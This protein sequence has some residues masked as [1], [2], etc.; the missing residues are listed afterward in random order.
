[1]SVTWITENDAFDFA[2]YSKY[3]ESVTVP[4]YERN[5]YLQPVFVCKFESKKNKTGR[6]WHAHI[7]KCQVLGAAYYA[8]LV[9]GPHQ[10]IDRFERHAFHPEKVFLDRYATSVFLPPEFDPAAAF[11]QCSNAGKAP[12]AV[13]PSSGVDDD[14]DWVKAESRYMIAT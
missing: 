3:A 4:L 5:D 12:L 1:M 10:S 2:I 7:S 14:F 13:L 9:D 6:I 11:G 8:Y